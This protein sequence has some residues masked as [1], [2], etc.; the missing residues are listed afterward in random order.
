MS[1]MIKRHNAIVTKVADHTRQRGWQTEV[2]PHVRHRDG[3]LFKPDLMIR[4]S[5][6]MGEGGQFGRDLGKEEVHLRQ[7]QVH[8]SRKGDMA[9]EGAGIPALHQTHY[10]LSTNVKLAV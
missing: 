8:R 10:S 9:R 3:T 7:S 2:E 1:I 4:L 5:R 6:V